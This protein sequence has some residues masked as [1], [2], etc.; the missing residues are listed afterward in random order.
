MPPKIA[1]IVPLPTWDFDIR[2]DDLTTWVGV[3]EELGQLK[4]K[5]APQRLVL[6]DDA[7]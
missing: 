2:R 6:A 3:L 7:G 5:V 4:R 1:K